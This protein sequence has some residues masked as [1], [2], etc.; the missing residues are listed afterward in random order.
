MKDNYAAEEHLIRLLHAYLTGEPAPEVPVDE[1]ESVVDAGFGQDMAPL[2]FCAVKN[3]PG[4]K[5]HPKYTTWHTQFMNDMMRGEIQ[6]SEYQRLVEHLCRNGAEILPLKGIEI[7]QLY[8]SPVLRVMSDVDMFFSGISPEKLCELM[9]ECGYSVGS[10]GTSHADVY[11][12]KPC[13]NIEMHRQIVDDDSPFTACVQGVTSSKIPDEHI[14]HL[15]HSR[16]EDLYIHVIAHAATHL[17]TSGL[18]VRPLCDIYVVNRAYASSWDTDYIR[19]MLDKDGLTAFSDKLSAI[20]QKWFGDG[21]PDFSLEEEAFFFN[22]GT[23][24]SGMTE[25]EWKFALSG[26]KGG[27]SYFLSRMFLPLSA[28]QKSYPVLKKAPILLPVFWVVQ[29]FNVLFHRK[30]R[31]AEV[32]KVGKTDREQIRYASRIVKALGLSDH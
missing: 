31:I 19:E 18:G 20:A 25:T 7:K 16:P 22:G 28:M 15:Y 5:S 4:A 6:L 9:T 14:P 13:M 10:I 1:L 24:G 2:T 17:L 27:F 11:Y 12:K 21:K 26:K 3:L 30:N 23:Y 8:P 29:W 32:A